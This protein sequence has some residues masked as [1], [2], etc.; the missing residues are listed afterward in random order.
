LLIDPS[1]HFLTI[2]ALRLIGL[3][4]WHLTRVECLENPFP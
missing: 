4:G 2:F 3:L 1:D